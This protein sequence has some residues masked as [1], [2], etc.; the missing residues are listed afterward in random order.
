MPE[1]TTHRPGTP[2]WVDLG[3]PDIEASAAF[4]G[5]VFGWDAP[6][7][8]DAEQTGGYRQAMKGDKP[9]AGMMPL[10]QEGQPPA[11]STY[12]SVEDADATAAAVTEA[13]G[14]VLAEPMDVLDLG[15]MA[16]FAD[17]E[18]AVFGIWQAGSFAGAGLVKEADTL[19][20]NELN[21]R[22]PE[23]AKSFYG[24]VFGWQYDEREFEA[25]L[26]TSIQADGE[27]V[28]GIIDI[29]D[30]VPDEVPAHWL[31]YFASDE[32]D[33]TIEKATSAGGE[34]VFGPE[35]ISEVGRI[36]VM[37]DPAGAVFAVIQPDPAMG[38]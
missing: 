15:R 17:P 18:G 26:Y 38:T 5:E 10:M 33:A 24:D 28:G 20:W 2:S 36:A 23:R 4:Y 21:T 16:V 27:T 25:G 32:A 9:V 22:D 37:K 3:S 6:E 13:G 30:R 29:S 34:V 19:V 31:V 1:M 35:D 7:S 8:E 11:W 14:T 12:I